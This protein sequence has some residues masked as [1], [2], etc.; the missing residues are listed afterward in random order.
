[1]SETTPVKWEKH[2]CSFCKTPCY[3]ICYIGN[4]LA[5]VDCF[6]RLAIVP[7]L[8]EPQRPSPLGRALAIITAM[9]D[10]RKGKPFSF[11]RRR[12]R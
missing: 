9:R 4:R 5:C 12:P 7:T 2:P 11:Q 8:P 6:Y 10:H 1:V 3:T